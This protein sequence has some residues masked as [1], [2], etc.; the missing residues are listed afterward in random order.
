MAAARIAAVTS[1][2][3]P[4]WQLVPYESRVDRIQGFGRRQ[5]CFAVVDIKHQAD[6]KEQSELE[7]YDHPA[8]QQSGAALFLVARCQKALDQQLL[9]AVA[10]GGQEAA[11]DNSGPEGVGFREIFRRW[12][13]N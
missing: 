9:G 7:E 6:Q 5:A 12:G 4:G 1:P 8:T 3:I 2:A 11:T 10:G 13:R